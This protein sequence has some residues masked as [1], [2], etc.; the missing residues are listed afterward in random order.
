M[1]Q[2]L[3]KYHKH[4]DKC[5]QCRNHPFNLCSKG[6]RILLVEFTKTVDAIKTALKK[7]G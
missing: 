2:D 5:P 4:L 6:E 1:S 3:Y 7:E